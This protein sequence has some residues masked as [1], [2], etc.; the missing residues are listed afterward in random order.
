MPTHLVEQRSAKRLAQILSSRRNRRLLT[1]ETMTLASEVEAG[2][3][4]LKPLL[5]SSRFFAKFA[6]FPREVRASFREVRASFA[7]FALFPPSSRL[8]H[9]V[10]ASF[11]EV[12]AFLAKF[13][14][15]P[16]SSRFFRR[17]RA[18]FAEFALFSPSSRFSCQVRVFFVKFAT[19]GIENQ[20]EVDPNHRILE[21]NVANTRG[22]G[23]RRKVA[24]RLGQTARDRQS[25]SA[26]PGHEERPR[27][28]RPQGQSQ[29]GPDAGNP[30]SVYSGRALAGDA[31]VTDDRSEDDG[32]IGLV[33]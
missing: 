32:V 26:R 27:P 10:R 16:R 1:W 21:F 23:E 4:K 18:F 20:S 14:L 3:S 9:E 5:R 24:K 30:G 28:L 2:C 22:G 29:A 11:R 15:F 12:R 6:P 31:I 8:F 25:R 13:A 33:Q 7:K 19:L 17:V